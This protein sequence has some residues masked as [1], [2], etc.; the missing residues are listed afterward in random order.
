MKPD[1]NKIPGVKPIMDAAVN[2]LNERNPREKLMVLVFGGIFIFTVDYFIWLA[3][4]VNVLT[5]TMPILSSLNEELDTLKSDKKAAPE[6]KKKWD[7]IQNELIEKEKGFQ[8]TDQLPALLENLSKL[9]NEAGVRITSV[10][11]VGDSVPVG[12]KLYFSVPLQMNASAGGH[13]LGA[14]LSKLETDQIFYKVTDLKIS[15]NPT[16]P[17]KHSI[18]MMLETYRKA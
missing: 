14:F 9:A 17:R 12:N 15:Q 13:E 7:N 4:V 2:F 8:G 1:W 6:I 3:P 11:P 16:N 18:E 5:K 10:K